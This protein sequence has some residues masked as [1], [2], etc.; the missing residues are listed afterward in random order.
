MTNSFFY[1]KVQELLTREFSKKSLKGLLAICCLINTY[2]L[3]N[4]IYVCLMCN[5]QSD[6]LLLFIRF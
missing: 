6:F 4:L 3:S 1:N 2:K 5:G